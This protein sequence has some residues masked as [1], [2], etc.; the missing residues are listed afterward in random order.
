MIRFAYRSRQQQRV[1]D[2]W[3]RSI[4]RCRTCTD[5]RSTYRHWLVVS[6]QHDELIGG[7]SWDIQ[8]DGSNIT[9]DFQRN[10]IVGIQETVWVGDKLRH[11]N[12]DDEHLLAIDGD[13]IH[14][15]DGLHWYDVIR[16]ALIDWRSRTRRGHQSLWLKIAY[17]AGRD[18]V[19]S[20]RHSCRKM[21]AECFNI[22]ATHLCV[23]INMRANEAGQNKNLA[24]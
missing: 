13:Q 5:E 19:T 4:H 3:M 22:S 14:C 9:D 8:S 17:L 18:T 6:E 7:N 21:Y 15:R 1:E 10:R 23:T 24:H 12:D 16:T 20:T 11:D 2:C